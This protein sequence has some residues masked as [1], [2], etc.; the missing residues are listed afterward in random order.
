MSHSA[1]VSRIL[2]RGQTGPGAGSAKQNLQPLCEAFIAGTALT[3]G[4]FPNEATEVF[5]LCA[6]Y[7]GYGFAEAHARAFAQYAYT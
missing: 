1:M 6:R 4:D 3:C 2:C 5:G 7:H